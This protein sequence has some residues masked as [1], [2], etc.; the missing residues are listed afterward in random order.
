MADIYLD[1]VTNFLRQENGNLNATVTNIIVDW[2]DRSAGYKIESLLKFDGQ[3]LMF[4][5]KYRESLNSDQKFQFTSKEKVLNFFYELLNMCEK[6]LQTQKRT[7]ALSQL[8]DRCLE[9]ILELGGDI[10]AKK[11]E[12]QTAEA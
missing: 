1:A 7:F 5:T 3:Y 8:R 11:D 9:C 4:I 12:D 6:I 10:V 2:R